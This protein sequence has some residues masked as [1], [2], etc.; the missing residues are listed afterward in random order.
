MAAETLSRQVSGPEPPVVTLVERGTGP[1]PGRGG[2]R[3]HCRRA[4]TPATPTRYAPTGAIVELARSVSRRAARC[5]MR[6]TMK[7][8]T[9]HTRDR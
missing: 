3:L 5:S 2:G 4:A 1:N 7:G 9:R 6:L 8:W